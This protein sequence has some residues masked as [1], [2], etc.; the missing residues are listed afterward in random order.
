MS[1]RLDGGSDFKI[2][3]RTGNRRR[4]APLWILPNRPEE[5]LDNNL[6]MDCNAL[7]DHVIEW[8][9]IADSAPPIP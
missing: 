8:R 1:R 2:S 7:L 9:N 4:A 5:M 3:A 6:A